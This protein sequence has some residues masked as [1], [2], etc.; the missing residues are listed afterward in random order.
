MKN[1]KHTHQRAPAEQ[2]GYTAF[3]DVLVN[4]EVVRMNQERLAKNPPRRRRRIN[5]AKKIMRDPLVFTA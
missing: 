1:N 5:Y 3:T 2:R 4:P